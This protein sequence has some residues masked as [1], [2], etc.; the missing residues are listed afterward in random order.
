M[1]Y[2]SAKIVAG[3]PLIEI[4]DDRSGGG[5]RDLKE[6]LRELVDQLAALGGR[7]EI[8]S[9]PGVRPCVSARYRC[10]RPLKAGFCS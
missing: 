5:D 4:A 10:G 3:T 1:R 2:S 9:P 8:D 7:L 6:G